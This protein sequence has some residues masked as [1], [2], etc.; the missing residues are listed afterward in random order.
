M[1]FRIVKPA[2]D[3]GIALACDA[4]GIEPVLAFWRERVGARFDHTL[5]LGPGRRQHRHLWGESVLKLNH[6]RDGLAPGPAAGWQRLLLAEPDR[7]VAEQLIDPE[8][9]AVS[10][11]PKGTDG[12]DQLG[13]ELRVPDL[14]A[15]R[16]FYREGLRFDALAPD[17]LG[18]GAS[19]L[20]LLE[21]P[22][23]P[24]DPPLEHPGYAYVTV[25]VDAVDAAW[26]HAL[27]HGGRG[28]MEPTTLG[29]VARIAFVLDPA[30]NW[31]ELSQRRS[32]V[33]H[34]GAASPS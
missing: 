8:G 30:G 1:S 17:L 32:L 27:N 7:S 15:A 25:Q 21:D 26:E 18:L 24:T 2:L 14:G 23:A 20:R 34:L 13:I 6:W 5:A 10:L 4:T 22:S 3:V 28:A 16:R 33:G 12:I 19:R 29:D 11:L 9:N 31:I